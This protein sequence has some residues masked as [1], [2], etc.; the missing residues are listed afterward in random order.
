MMST[1]LQRMDARRIRENGARIRREREEAAGADAL[2]LYRAAHAAAGQVC[3]VRVRSQTD[4]KLEYM[5]QFVATSPPVVT[6][7]CRGYNSHG[8]CK[9]AEAVARLIEEDPTK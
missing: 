5:V 4:P 9:H 2:D 7:N 6:C 3:T 8:H 1:P